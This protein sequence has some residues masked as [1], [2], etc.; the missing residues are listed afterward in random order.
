[1]P[2]ESES[3]KHGV[4]PDARWSVSTAGGALMLAVA[5]VVG[6]AIGAAGEHL[7]TS[8]SGDTATTATLR[9]EV[10]RLRRE[11]D[12]AAA[13]AATAISRGATTTTVGPATASNLA[14]VTSAGSA[15]GR[16]RIQSPSGTTLSAVSATTTPTAGFPP[17]LTDLVGTLG[18]TMKGLT[19]HATADVVIQ[20]PV[21]SRPSGILRRYGSG[22]VDVSATATIARDSVTL[23]VQDG[24]VGDTDGAANGVVVDQLV[25][26]RVTP[27][28]TATSAPACVFAVTT[29]ALPAAPSGVQYSATLSAGC[30][31]PPLHWR[32]TG[33]LPGGLRLDPWSGVISG[34]T[35][36]AAGT[37]TFTVR[38][39]QGSSSTAATKT[40]SITVP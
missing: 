35:R 36:S 14:L 3:A 32:K 1:M 17:G 30:A 33:R 7:R 26:V 22:Y 15:P 8:G 40:L 9:R 13:R 18:Y 4:P 23:H 34:V 25:A 31:T 21:N 28:T 37:F 2:G 29:P 6:L 39:T 20:L 27:I 38:V 12:A 24:G 19:P 5:L 10:D 16:V 11:R